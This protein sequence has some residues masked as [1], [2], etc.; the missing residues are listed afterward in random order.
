MFIYYVK[1]YRHEHNN[2]AKGSPGYNKRQE[3]LAK[4][5]IVNV[6]QR[7]EVKAKI[8]QTLKEKYGVSNP[9]HLIT[10]KNNGN[11]SKPHLQTIEFLKSRGYIEHV[12][13]ISEQRNFLNAFNEELNR[14]YCPRPDIIFPDKKVVIE[15]YGNLWHANPQ[16]YSKLD[17]IHTWD[18]DLT[19]GEIWK[20]DKIRENHIKSLGYDVIILWESEIT[21]NDFYKL[22]E[23]GL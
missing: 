7:E 10:N 22:I 19:A 17:I 9:I 14:D 20:R 18:G 8:K 3:T 11:I 12:D 15:I 13:F 1:K 16:Y 6:F 23:Y 21:K 4:E 2:L 5:G